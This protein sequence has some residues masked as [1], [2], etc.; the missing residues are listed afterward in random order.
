MQISV[1][2]LTQSTAWCFKALII[3]LKETLHFS[4]EISVK[5]KLNLHPKREKIGNNSKHRTERGM[6]KTLFT[7]MTS[8]I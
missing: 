1:F 6:N 7:D 4:I 8:W 5:F 3:V 2:C